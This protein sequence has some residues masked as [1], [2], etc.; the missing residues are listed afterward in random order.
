ML[1][2]VDL[3]DVARTVAAAFEPGEGGVV[4]PA[5]AKEAARARL[6]A[7]AAS[8]RARAVEDLMAVAT[9]LLLEVG[10]ETPAFLDVVDLA[11]VGS[12]EGGRA[13]D[14]RES[15]EPRRAHRL[16]S[17]DAGVRAPRDDEPKPNAHRG[18]V[19]A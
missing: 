13:A 1:P 15:T 3:V 4:L 14:A 10:R 16:L 7:M 19:R 2:A 8:E 17:Q 18:P 5:G 11:A 12:W 9:R 6:L